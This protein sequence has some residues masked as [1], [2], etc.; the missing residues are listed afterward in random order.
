MNGRWDDKVITSQ[1]FPN[2]F[3]NIFLQSV[4]GFVLVLTANFIVR[5]VDEDSALF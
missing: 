5:K 4:L 1:A 3:T 2:L